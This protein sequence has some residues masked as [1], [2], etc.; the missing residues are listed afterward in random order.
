MRQLRDIVS[1]NS[2]FYKYYLSEPITNFQIVT[3]RMLLYKSNIIYTAIADDIVEFFEL[4]LLSGIILYSNHYMVVAIT[5]NRFSI[6]KLL[7]KL[8]VDPSQ[9]DSKDIYPIEYATKCGFNEIATYL[10]YTTKTYK[11]NDRLLVLA[12]QIN[13]ETMFTIYYQDLDYIN[14]IYLFVIYQSLIVNDNIELFNQFR[15]DR[16]DYFD[17]IAKLVNHNNDNLLHIAI[18][19]KAKFEFIKLLVEAGLNVNHLNKQ[20]N[21]PLHYSY[22]SNIESISY[23]VNQKADLTIQNNL[24]LRPDEYADVMGFSEIAEYLSEHIL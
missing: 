22:K 19:R 14:D 16:P 10:Y 5:L 20:G 7:I 21:T 11:F 13:N 6:I 4:L 8:G 15:R 12:A 18:D 3:N 23:L 2:T 9:P 24:K 17:R 1:P